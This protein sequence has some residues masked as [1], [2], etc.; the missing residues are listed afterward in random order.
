MLPDQRKDERHIP[1]L[2]PSPREVGRCSADEVGAR[3]VPAWTTRPGVLLEGVSMVMNVLA[4]ALFGLLAGIVA[5]FI[6]KQPE[7]FDLIGLVT[8]ALLGVAGA[9]VGGWL[10]SVLFSWDINTFSIAGFAVAVAGALLLVFLYRLLMSA[11]K[12]L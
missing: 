11:R 3:I 5:K 8:T 12:T 4:W 9:V 7:R 2:A 10:S 6:G 1:S